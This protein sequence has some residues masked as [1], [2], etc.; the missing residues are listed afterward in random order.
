VEEEIR[1][2]SLPLEDRWILSR[3]NRTVDS[4]NKLMG[5]FQFEEVQRQVYDFL[6]NEYCDWYIEM[7]KVRLRS[8]EALS[9]VPVLVHVLE[10]SLRLLHPF[11]PFITEELWQNL[12]GYLPERSDV[13]DSIMVAAYPEADEKAFDPEAERVMEAIIETVRSIRNARAQYNVENSRWI[14]ARVYAGTL[15]PAIAPYSG[16]IETLA[17][18]RP[19]SIIDSRKEDAAGENALVLVLKETEVVIPMESMVDLEA[20]KKRLENEIARNQAEAERVEAR[21]KDT[22]FTSKAPGAVVE[23]ERQKYDL[24]V[25]KIERLK[26][27]ILKY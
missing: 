18:A 4:V 15:G 12:K 13:A 5:D 2:G 20:E 6:W 7:A 24:L 10:V 1:W 3:L 8:E 25:E 21:L 19:V 16:A 27:Q 9:P 23:K 17:R 14:E 22:N 26:Q 11:M